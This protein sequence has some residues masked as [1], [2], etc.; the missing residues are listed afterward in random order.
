MICMSYVL[1]LMSCIY[2]PKKFGFIKR[3]ITPEAPRRAIPV[4]T[5]IIIPFPQLGLPV[6]III[7]PIIIKTKEIIRINVTNILVKLHIKTGKAVA[8]VTLVS[9]GPLFAELSSIQL[10]IKG[11]D[12]LSDIP[13]QTHSALQEV[14]YPEIFLVHVGQS[15]HQRAVSVHHTH[16]TLELDWEMP[17]VDDKGVRGV[18]AGWLQIQHWYDHQQEEDWIHICQAPSQTDGTTLGIS[19]VNVC[20]HRKRLA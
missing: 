1:I 12:V 3:K 13:Q 6:A 15:H 4:T 10:P 16:F 20:V 19:Q 5:F 8:Q 17:H 2:Y 14:Q 11:I 7:P 18:I 9:P